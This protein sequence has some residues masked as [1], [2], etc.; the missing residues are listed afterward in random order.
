[1]AHAS[2]DCYGVWFVFPCD[3][4]RMVYKY[5]IM[6]GS[7]DVANFEFGTAAAPLSEKKNKLYLPNPES[8]TT[9]LDS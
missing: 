7:Y 5:V 1:M 9:P 2:R 6:L 3:K 4:T 8:P